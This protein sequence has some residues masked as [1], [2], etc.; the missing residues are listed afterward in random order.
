MKKRI[1]FLISDTGG[2]HRSSA[3]ALAQVFSEKYNITCLLP[4]FFREG[5]KP[6]FR[7]FPDA[8]ADITKKRN[9]FYG[10]LWYGIYPEPFYKFLNWIVDITSP[11]GLREFYER[12][13]PFDC[14]V[15]CHAL[16]NHF[17]LQTLRRYYHKIPFYIV[18]IDLL[19]LHTG[20]FERGADFYFLPIPESEFFFLKR[21]FPKEKLG[22][23]GFPIRKEFFLLQNKEE[24]KGKFGVEDKKV[25]LIIGGGEGIGQIKEVASSFLKKTDYQILIVTGRNEVLFKS[26]SETY[27]SERRIRVF[28]FV[29]N[30]YELLSI[31]DL[32]ITKA[33]SST[34]MEAVAKK[35]PLILMNYTYG[36][37]AGNVRWVERRGLG[38]YE[39]EP[40][41]IL[42]KAQRILETDLGG[43]IKEKMGKIN[44]A[45]ASER[46][47]EKIVQLLE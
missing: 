29:N 8:Y 14:V 38:F 13:Y 33:G 24:L 40:A 6:P 4:D 42:I 36:Q 16:L 28:G 34:I 10:L 26:L 12:H 2:G 44:L 15:S 32:C 11:N 7:N 41:E 27:W 37:E 43:K 45:G 5:T 35:V 25:V 46:I 9:Y 47:C 21:G 31:S 39:K 20:W 18:V 1:L 22:V 3:L 17:P 30:I 19:S 23:Y